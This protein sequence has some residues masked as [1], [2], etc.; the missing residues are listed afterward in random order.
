MG[1]VEYKFSILCPS[2]NHEKYISCFVDSVLSQKYTNF[3]LIIIDDNSSDNT[4]EKVKK[5]DDAR[6]KVYKNNINYGI[7]YSINRAYSYSTGDFVVMLASDDMI[8]K[9]FLDFMNR[10]LNK[11]DVDV[12]YNC[13]RVIDENGNFVKM[14]TNKYDGVYLGIN[15]L[16]DIFYNGNQL[17]SPGLIIK[18][19]IF[20]KIIPFSFS[21]CSLQD[22]VMHIK[23][24]QISKIFFNNTEFLVLYRIVQHK[25][26]S[27]SNNLNGLIRAELE[28]YKMLDVFLEIDDVFCVNNITMKYDVVVKEPNILRYYLGLAALKSD[29]I[30]HQKWGY[31]QIMN[32]INEFGFDYLYEKEKLDFA[33][34]LGLTP[35]FIKNSNIQKGIDNFNINNKYKKYKHYF[36]NSVVFTLFVIVGF[37]LYM[38]YFYEY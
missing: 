19:S 35:K 34:F 23:L 37:V 2:Y 24:L 28:T 1:N 12:I 33:S 3:E 17:L 6:L 11:Y 5:Y 26:V 32:I 36:Y 21:F 16:P 9:N 25:N 27:A 13:L 7:N 38:R 10:L 30:E 15:I 14:C 8:D 4:Y 22:V 29:N 31:I 18:N 20:K